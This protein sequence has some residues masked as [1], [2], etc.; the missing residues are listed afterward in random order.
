MMKKQFETPV[1][2]VNWFCIENIVTTS[3][4]GSNTENMKKSMETDGY[5]VKTISIIDF[6][7]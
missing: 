2:K 7:F 3:G 4:T 6:E 5:S 1:I